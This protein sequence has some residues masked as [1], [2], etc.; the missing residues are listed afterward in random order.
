MCRFGIVTKISLG[1]SAPVLKKLAK[2]IG[3]DHRLALQL[4]KTKILEARLLASLIDDPEKVNEHQMEKWAGDFD[5]WAVCD[6]CCSYLFDK[7]P[8]AWAKAV[9]WSG[10]EEEFVKRAG[11]VLMA[12]LAVHNKTAADIRYERFFR[13]IERESTDERNF[14][15]KGVNWALRQIGKRNLSLHAK[16]ITTARSIKKSPSSSARWI[17]ADALRELTG[18]QV[19]QRLQRKELRIKPLR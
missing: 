6:C 14:V 12:V 4:W 19:C 8:F 5:N 16:A 17:A 15:K 2:E 13:L 1:I 11:F 7:T 3:T 18:P 9:E 10:R